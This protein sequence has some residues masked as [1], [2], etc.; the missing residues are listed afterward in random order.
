MK[1][2]IKKMLRLGLPV[3]GFIRPVIRGLYRL[4]VVVCE[5][6]V[7]LRKLFFVEPVLRSIATVGKGL[8]ADRLPYIRGNGKL[9]IGDNVRLSGESGFFFMTTEGEEPVIEIGDNVFIGHGCTVSSAR[10]VTIGRDVL[11]ASGVRIHDNDG[12]PH[13]AEK[14]KLGGKIG[15][16]EIAAVEIQ[17]GAWIGAGAMIMK[18][19]TVDENQIIGAGTVKRREKAARGD[20]RS[21]SS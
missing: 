2:M 20:V 1:E 5:G 12:H 9:I 19:V 4:G 15:D 7:F 8:R 3:P 18:G 10:K 21:S 17:D 13:D 6:L 11:I 14:R 16:K